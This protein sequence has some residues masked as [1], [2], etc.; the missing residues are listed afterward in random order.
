MEELTSFFRVVIPCQRLQKCEYAKLIEKRCDKLADFELAKAA[1]RGFEEIEK[2]RCEF[3]A[4][5]NHVKA[6]LPKIWSSINSKVKKMAEIVVNSDGLFFERVKEVLAGIPQTLLQYPLAQ[7]ASYV[8]VTNQRLA[9]LMK[10]K[11][12]KA[13][14][15]RKSLRKSFSKYYF[16]FAEVIP[17]VYYL[18][19]F[20]EMCFRKVNATLKANSL[21][22]LRITPKGMP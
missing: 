10:F 20:Q 21:F 19:C 8:D 14:Q 16:V 3:E 2:K 22:D 17:L 11:M 5:N 9:S 6:N 13:R 12:E 15:D 4:L 1:G 18:D 7:F